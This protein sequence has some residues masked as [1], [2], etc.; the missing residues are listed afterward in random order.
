[1]TRMSLSLGGSK[2]SRNEK[3]GRQDQEEPTTRQMVERA[4]KIRA[5]RAQ[6][7]NSWTL[8]MGGSRGTNSGTQIMAAKPGKASVETESRASAA[9]AFSSL[10]TVTGGQFP[11]RQ[12]AT[13]KAAPKQVS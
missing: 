10:T 6:V 7:F 1:M 5:L 8:N 11:G 2:P 9:M 13:W 3:Y 4:G 12:R